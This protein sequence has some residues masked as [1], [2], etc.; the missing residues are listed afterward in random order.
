M[1]NN[2]RNYLTA[3]GVDFF[4][5][6]VAII[7]MHAIK[8]GTIEASSLYFKLFLIFYLTWFG[9]SII[10]KKFNGIKERPFYDG[11]ALIARS[12]IFIV[13]LV[14]FAIVGFHLI[15]LSRIQTFGTCLLFFLLEVAAF[16]IYYKVSRKKIDNIRLER[17]NG[18]AI[19][20]NRSYQLLVIDGLL[21]L[22]SFVIMNY[23]K[24]DSF[25]ILPMYEQVILVT[26][27]LWL[28]TS[29]ITKKYIRNNFGSFYDAYTPC[30][31]AFFIM[32]ASLAVM[33]FAFRLFYFS[34]LQVFGTL[35]ILLGFEAVV[36]YLYYAYRKFGK[37]AG[38]IESIE[39][40]KETIQSQVE[41]QSLDPEDI[42]GY[43]DDPVDE[44]LKNALEFFSRN[45][46]N[47]IKRNIDLNKISRAETALLSADDLFNI[48]ILDS[49]QHRLFVN[50][51]KLNDLRWFNQYFLE[52]HSKLKTGGYFIGTAHTITTRR[53]HY[54]DKY[55]KYLSDIF[56]AINFIW[57]RVFP[58][59]PILQKIYFALTRGRNRMV[60][61]AE[62][63]GRLNFCG[64][65]IIGEMEI[66]NRLYYIAQKIKM[67]S[68]NENP[69]YGP[70]IE[71][72]RSG[73]NGHM[74]QVYKFRTMHPYSEFLQDYIYEKYN[75]DEGGKFHN[76][77]RVTAWG[78]FMR[79]KWLD[80]I[81]MIYNWIKGDIKLFGVRPLSRQYLNLYTDELKK[82]REKVKPGLIP[83]YYVDLPKTLDEICESEQKYIEAYLKHPVSTQWKYFW[84]A[85]SNIVIK[86]HRSN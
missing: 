38:D 6:N 33:I 78:K 52:V 34:R 75:L 20:A 67:P 64:F 50:L 15:A 61:K 77:I 44:K 82:L 65:K 66:E 23:L 58:K 16:S 14:A 59:L 36:Y 19:P 1:K 12:N 54:M 21:V 5:L 74:I 10:T 32:A 11:L 27:G 70:L 62:V 2:I 48:R 80:E 8:Q 73:Q 42:Q 51:T 69:T 43:V 84:K 28:P 56:Y 83:P 18:D 63:F 17:P 68:T 57:C 71:L 40:V 79:E 26:Y 47:F 30:I 24:R 53:Q 81:P 55:S 85:F 39:K 7:G 41:E 46:Y 3:S 4:L 86:G 13:Y 22:I 31:K 72:S 29:I 25:Y 37:I 49:N 60:S 35:V 76:D 9:V 45:L